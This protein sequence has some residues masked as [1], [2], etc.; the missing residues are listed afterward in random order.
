MIFNSVSTVIVV[1]LIDYCIE[2]A[3]QCLNSKIVVLL[4]YYCTLMMFISVSTVI[5]VILIDYCILRMPNNV[6]TVRLWSY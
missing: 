3:E 6:S 4:I 2:N 5:V 1:I